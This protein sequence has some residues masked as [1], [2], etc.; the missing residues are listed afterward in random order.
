MTELL[1]HAAC[2]E[3]RKFAVLAA[4]SERQCIE[5]GHAWSEDELSD[6]EFEARRREYFQESR[7]S[8]SSE[9]E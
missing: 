6:E 1:L 4:D 3:C 5:C 8:T 2:P 7:R 9:E